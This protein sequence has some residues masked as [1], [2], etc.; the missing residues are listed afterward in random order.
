MIRGATLKSLSTIRS[1]TLIPILI[2]KRATTSSRPTPSSPQWSSTIS[3]MVVTTTIT[4]LCLLHTHLPPH[5][6]WWHLCFTNHSHCVSAVQHLAR[7]HPPCFIILAEDSITL[8]F[9]I[10][11]MA[12]VSS[13]I[14]LGNINQVTTATIIIHL[15]TTVHKWV[16]V[17]DIVLFIHHLSLTTIIC[18]R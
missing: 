10:S 13:Q 4:R 15:I 1:T 2:A 7:L 5:T 16:R 8:R 14:Y 9:L 18:E 6:T 17:E 12:W 11:R 3:I